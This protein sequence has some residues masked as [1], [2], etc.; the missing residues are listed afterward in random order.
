MAYKRPT[1]P[2]EPYMTPAVYHI[3]LALGDGERHGYAILRTIAANT[4]APSVGPT[5]LYRS[6]RHMLA[7]GFVEVADERPDP[8][9]DNERREYY[10]LTARGREVARAETER[11]GRIVAAAQAKPL[12]AAPRPWAVGMPVDTPADI[13]ADIP[14]DTSADVTTRSWRPAGAMGGA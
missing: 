7:D 10:R 4:D 9:L 12:L 5:T 13:P 3:L 6:L 14:T 2:T 11:M 1:A 8:A